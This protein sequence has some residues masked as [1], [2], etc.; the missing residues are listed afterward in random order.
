MLPGLER[1]RQAWKTFKEQRSLGS[2][3]LQAEEIQT[4]LAWL[5]VPSMIIALEGMKV[6]G[7]TT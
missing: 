3:G 7:G 6:G 5:L 1:L 2:A 4:L